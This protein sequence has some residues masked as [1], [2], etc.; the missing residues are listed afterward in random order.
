MASRSWNRVEL[1]GNLTRD[2]ELRY[3]PNGAAVCT[4]GMAT[5]RVYTTVDGEKKEEAEFHRLVAW[6]KLAE[7][8]GQYLKKGMKVFVS[9]RL[10]YREWEPQEGQK[11]KDAEISVDDM[12][13]L[14][15]KAYGEPTATSDDLNIEPV[16]VEEES[17]FAKASVKDKTSENEVD[18]DVQEAKPIK[19]DTSE[20][21]QEKKVPP[22][23]EVK[24]DLPF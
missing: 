9:G 11:R 4:F 1:I 22:Q 17:S 6:R 12:V 8:C 7:I 10:Q 15:P 24:D 21:V 18:V 14:T 23:E 16:K 20:S 19:K 13:I 2:P 3:T 5:N